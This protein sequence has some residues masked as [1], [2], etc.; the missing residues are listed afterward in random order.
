M[1]ACS[2]P[3]CPAPP[4]MSDVS[5]A[6]ARPWT[7]HHDSSG[8]CLSA[9]MQAHHVGVSEQHLTSPLGTVRPRNGDDSADALG[10]C[11]SLQLLLLAC[12]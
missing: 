4:C 9:A 2:C 1:Q 7:A 11:R 3:G 10:A 8:G 12:A 5:T 6:P